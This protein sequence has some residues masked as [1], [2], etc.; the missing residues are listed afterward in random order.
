MLCCIHGLQ[1]PSAP[2]Q[3][4]L[5]TESV[6]EDALPI[7]DANEDD[8]EVPE[9]DYVSAQLLRQNEILQQ[10]HM[11]RSKVAMT[12]K[13]GEGVSGAVFKGLLN[14]TRTVAVKTLLEHTDTNVTEFLQEAAI[15]ASVQHPKIVEIIG[16]CVK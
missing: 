6:Y 13:L 14:G 3:G 11:D 4:G 8:Y 16:L 10:F 12:K 9:S 7:P 5:T 2:Q 1:L 15:M